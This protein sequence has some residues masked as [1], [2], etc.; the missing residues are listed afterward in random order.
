MTEIKF[1]FENNDYKCKKNDSIALALM[2]NNILDLNLNEV[3]EWRGY[4]CGMGIC[5]ECL[6]ECNGEI[7]KSCTKK[8]NSGDKIKTKGRIKLKNK[9]S[10][11]ENSD[12]CVMM[13][14]DVVV[15]GGGIS[16]MAAGFQLSKVGINVI[17]I[18]SN[19]DLGGQYL[20]NINNNSNNSLINKINKSNIQILKNTDVFAI[21]DKFEIWGK[22]TKNLYKIKCNKIIVASG[23]YEDIYPVHNWTLP[24][25][26]QTGSIQNIIKAYNFV[27][28][29]NYVVYGN[30]P[31]ILDVSK[32]IKKNGGKISNVFEIAKKPS[33]TKIKNL[34][35]MSLSN[36]FLMVKGLVTLL[37]LKIKSID[38]S[39]G[40]R[41][42]KIEKKDKE[43]RCYFE[44]ISSSKEVIVDTDYLCVGNGFISNNYILRFL[45]CET[46]FNNDLKLETVVNE[47]MMT[48]INN[49]YAVGDCK[50]IMGSVVGYY[51]GLLCG[52]GIIE[53]MKNL[54]LID[55]INKIL[56]NYKLLLNK[57][58]QKYL[59][60]IY[61][62]NNNYSIDDDTY[63]CRC[64]N[65][66][67]KSIVEQL[68]EYKTMNKLKVET[69]VGMGKCQGRLCNNIL[70]NILSQ[71]GVKVSQ[72]DFYNIRMPLIPTK[73]GIITQNENN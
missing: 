43:I 63:I 23:A 4:F 67:Y 2:K 10:E 65:V 29:K 14:A 48:S 32:N 37:Y 68:E 1:E 53:E 17:L 26:I 16:G 46:K 39:Y 45:N 20:K 34:I 27:P 42:K 3:D 44:H 51:E 11:L 21:F 7:V 72:N 47:K 56:V 52:Y 18:D 31:F 69:R 15:I 66:K 30:G 40:V 64:E 49:V 73:I 19:D 6:V 61:K 41:L 8:I 70:L 13:N 60:N 71:N 36:P 9:F 57:L 50:N 54:N 59:W 24:N 22:N 5:N 12:D 25:V 62:I 55:K 33:V 58:F 35:M 28:D 38:V